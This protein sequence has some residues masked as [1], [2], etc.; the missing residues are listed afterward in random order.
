M[1]E[2]AEIELSAGQSF[3]LRGK[4]DR[5]D[6]IRENLYRV[7]DYK[8]GSYSY[9]DALE[10]F[11]RGKILQHVLYSLAA[12]Q[13]IERLGLDG[14][15]EVVESGYYFPTRKGEG[16][17]VL[18]KRFDRQRMRELLWALLDV[19][20]EGNFVSSPDAGCDYCDY[21]PIC[22]ADAPDKAKVKREANE[23]AFALF[24]RLKEYD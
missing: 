12:E 4:I 2:P 7:I 9:Y 11:G 19:L 13:I 16:H 5:I 22:P 24:D 15:P 8:T 10:H 3:K 17:E 20:S 14:T 6:R 21:S 23:S 18:V 1:E